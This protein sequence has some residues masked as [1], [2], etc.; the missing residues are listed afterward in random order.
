[1]LL[2]RIL[3][4][5]ICRDFIYGASLFRQHLL[6]PGPF[7]VVGLI[8]VLAFPP[9]FREYSTANARE[10][11]ISRVSRRASDF[12]LLRYFTSVFHELC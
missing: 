11:K 3:L 1:M 7:L 5:I 8:A 9:L 2:D 10:L 4:I 12:F 6:Q